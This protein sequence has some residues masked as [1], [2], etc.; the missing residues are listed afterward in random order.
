MTEATAQVKIDTED[1]VRGIGE[2][3][4]SRIAAFCRVAKL[5]LD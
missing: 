5:N 3:L 2:V 4:T 1:G